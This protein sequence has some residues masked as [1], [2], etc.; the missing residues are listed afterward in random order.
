[1]I[2]KKNFL[3]LADAFLVALLI[4]L[5]AKVGWLDEIDLRICDKFFQEEGARNADIIVLGIDKATLNR[6]GP[7]SSI[8]RRDMAQAIYYLNNHDPDARPDRKS[9]V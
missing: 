7:N 3:R 8:R 1:M 4:T 6:L 2:S 5:V 9:V